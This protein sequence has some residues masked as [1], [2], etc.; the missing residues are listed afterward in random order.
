MSCDENTC[1]SLS[2]WAKKLISQVSNKLLEEFPV[3]GDET[4]ATELTAAIQTAFAQ[5]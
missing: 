3:L 4:F 1:K 2:C 5:P